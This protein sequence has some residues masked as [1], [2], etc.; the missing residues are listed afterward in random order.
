M[1]AMVRALALRSARRRRRVGATRRRAAARAGGCRR[2]RAARRSTRRPT[3]LRA[4]FDYRGDVTLTL[5]DGSRVE[6]F[7]SD[8]GPDAIQFWPAG[9]EAVA[10]AAARVRHVALTG[11]DPAARRHAESAAPAPA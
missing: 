7:V 11:R 6:G 1:L 5:D 9:S 4:A 2:R 8:P 3:S 10:L